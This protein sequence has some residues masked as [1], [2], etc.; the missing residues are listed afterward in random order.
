MHILLVEDDATIS[1]ELTLRWQRN[2]W[3]VHAA[4]T[5]ADAQRHYDQGTTELIV[6]D[7]GLPDGDGQHWLVKLR[8]RDR[9]TP[10]LVLTARDRVVDRVQGLQSGAD[11]YMVKPFSVDELDARID[12]LTRR[13]ERNEGRAG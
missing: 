7:M 11:D 10:V 1:R 9:N 5:L 6:L 8:E 3:Q 4:G 2:G 13:V 12:V